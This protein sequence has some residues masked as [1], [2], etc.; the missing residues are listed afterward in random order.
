[1]INAARIA[2]EFDSML[3]PDEIP[4]KTEGYEGFHHLLS[5]EGR[6]EEASAKY[7][8]RDHSKEKFAAKKAEF[9]SV[10]ALLNK[11]YGEG[12]RIFKM[13]P[14]HH[15]FQKEGIPCLFNSSAKALP[16]AKIVT[17]FWIVGMIL[18]VVTIALLKVR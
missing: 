7:I 2:A 6:T 12:R 11:K 17:R 1:M 5:I 10:S 15:H 3:T 18:A 9:E 16:E 8:I 4:E 14:L 13:A